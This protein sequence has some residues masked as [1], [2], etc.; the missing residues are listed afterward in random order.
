[1][2]TGCKLIIAFANQ[3]QLLQVIMGYI[4]LG[5][6]LGSLSPQRSRFLQSADM[7]R[8]DSGIVVQGGVLLSRPFLQ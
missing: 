3:T 4:R 6:P 2:V 8:C 1:M 7:D 5:I